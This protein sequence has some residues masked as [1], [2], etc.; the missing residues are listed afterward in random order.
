[1]YH[2]VS[3]VAICSKRDYYSSNDVVVHESI[4]HLLMSLYEQT[5]FVI[6]YVIV[7]CTGS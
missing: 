5:I 4:L 3:G 6:K 2:L 7:E 1:M